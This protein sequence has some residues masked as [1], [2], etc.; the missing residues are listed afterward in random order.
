MS[1][2]KVIHPVQVPVL[3]TVVPAPL[4]VAQ[5]Q[6]HMAVLQHLMILV[7]EETAPSAVSAATAVDWLK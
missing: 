3:A 2:A 1:L 6:A 4:V 5:A 7:R